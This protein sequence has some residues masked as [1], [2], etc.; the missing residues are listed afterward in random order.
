MFYLKIGLR[1]IIKNFRKTLLTLL[2]ISVGMAAL[3]V[4]SGSNNHMF[5]MLRD[6]IIHSQTGHFQLYKKGFPLYQ[7]EFPFDYLID[8][9]RDVLKELY[10]IPE[11]KFIAPRLKFSGLISSDKKSAMVMGQGGDPEAE[12]LMEND[13]LSAGNFLSPDDKS[14]DSILGEGLIKKL[15]GRIGDDFTLMAAMKGGGLNG[16]DITVKGVKKGGGESDVLSKMFLLA[17]LDNIQKLLN[18]PDSA[19]TLI[20]MLKDNKYINKVEPEIREICSRFGLEYKKWDELA[21]FYRSV[22]A[23]FNMNELVLTFIILFIIVFII[24]NTMIMNLMERMREIGTIRALGTTKAKVAKIFLGESF[25]LGLIGGFFGILMGFLAGAVINISGGIYHP[26]SV[27]NQSA[28]YTLIRPELSGILGYWLLFTAVS[29]VSAV[30]T[31]IKANKIS[32]AG[33]LRSIS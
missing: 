17:G 2:T 28:Y 7:N 30:L 16:L 9:Y 25:L 12:K 27:Y 33:A 10:K 18:V 5:Q 1:N 19:D 4:Y 29:A 13:P 26:P 24:A 22:K 31:I 6:Y 23:M 20:V 14:N 8:N 32:V 15:S 3:A 21:V 11:I